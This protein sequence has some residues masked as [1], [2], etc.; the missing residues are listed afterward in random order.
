MPEL[1]GSRANGECVNKNA[2]SVVCE[3]ARA[4]VVVVPGRMLA[5][6]DRQSLGEKI[7]SK[8][9]Q[10]AQWDWSEREKV[11]ALVGVNVDA[12]T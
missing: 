9:A 7:T 12:C 6:V 11:G 5:F 4:V 2:K 1:V 10:D 3:D 8:Y